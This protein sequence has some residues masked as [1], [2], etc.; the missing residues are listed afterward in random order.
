MIGIQ[1]SPGDQG[2]LLVKIERDPSGDPTKMRARIRKGTQEATLK[3]ENPALTGVAPVSPA[4]T[5]NPPAV[6]GQAAPAAKPP[7][8]PSP[9]PAVI[10][11]RI[12]PISPAR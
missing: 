7:S 4:A 9:A 1:P 12:V 11:R 6:P 8:P 2:M 5:G 10:R 3:Y